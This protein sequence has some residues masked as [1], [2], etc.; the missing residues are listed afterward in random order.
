MHN[1]CAVRVHIQ[2][3]HYFTRH[4]QKKNVNVILNVNVPTPGK[5]TDKNFCFSKN[6]N[7][8]STHL[9][10]GVLFDKGQ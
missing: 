5:P 2:K 7:A 3:K 8:F 9:N 6:I 1:E 10:Y 4:F